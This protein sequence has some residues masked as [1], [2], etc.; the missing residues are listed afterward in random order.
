MCTFGALG[1][2][3]VPEA[4]LLRHPPLFPL[5]SFFLPSR[6]L[7]EPLGPRN[8][9][10]PTL[11]ALLQH[12]NEKSSFQMRRIRVGGWGEGARFPSRHFLVWTVGDSKARL[13]RPEAWYPDVQ[14][15][16]QRGRQEGGGEAC[17]C[18]EMEWAEASG[19]RIE[20]GG[21]VKLLQTSSEAALSPP[22]CKDG[23]ERLG[24]EE[25]PPLPRP[26]G[27]SSLG[28]ALWGGGSLPALGEGDEGQSYLHQPPRR[29]QVVHDRLGLH[30]LPHS[31][32]S[33]AGR[34]LLRPPQPRGE[35]GSG[36][37]GH[38]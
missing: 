34:S 26:S 22:N 9:G 18:N 14:G 7:P 16:A 30:F 28:P 12:N 24:E 20:G 2:P 32:T 6:L 13:R 11:T 17:R 35:G 1:R 3:V 4:R 19:E 23:R 29:V 25:P 33:R 27:A 15:E 10:K 36:G 31:S 8:Q 37:R 38:S 5:L 21:Y